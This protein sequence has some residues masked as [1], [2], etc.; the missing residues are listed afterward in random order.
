M[1]SE[2]R[3]STRSSKRA[4]IQGLRALAVVL[5]I[6]N[7]A[8]GWPAGGFI[9]LD[10]FFVIS[11]Y[12]ATRVLYRE[13]EHSGTLR[14]LR[15]Y[16]RRIRRLAPVALITIVVTLAASYFLLG[17]DH[18][19]TV[20]QDALSAVLLASNWRF[21][22]AGASL[23]QAPTSPLE[24]FWPLS[25]GGQFLVF[26]PL[27][28]LTIAVIAHRTTARRIIAGM[29]VT[30]LTL[31]LLVLAIELTVS[32]PKTAYIMT[33]ARLWELF[34]GAAIALARPAFDRAGPT[35]QAVLSLLGLAGIIA[36]AFLTPSD[37]GYPA[38]WGALTALC[39]ALVLAFPWRPERPFL[40]PLSNPVTVYLGDI[41][42]SFYLWFFP[43]AFFVPVAFGGKAG[44][45]TL[46]ASII[47]IAV[48]VGLAALSYR[49]VEKPLRKSD[50]L[51]PNWFGRIFG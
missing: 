7:H 13:Y 48:A 43:L 26:W 22:D 9:G 30:S 38:P 4:D 10:V 17:L 36:A 8:F 23:G 31:L 15:F 28:L 3:A 21:A 34:A 32:D 37:A 27:L 29:I 33:S 6:A 40:N 19:L 24:Q 12:L 45:T 25:I 16:R 41:S 20:A 47:A 5:I 11:G 2:R 14:F 42:Y 35:I 49:F 46:L 44:S 51:E 50:V 39:T 1:T 18:F